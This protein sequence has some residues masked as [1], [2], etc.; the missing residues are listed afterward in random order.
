MK[1]ESL[2]LE[3]FGLNQTIR[4]RDE[5]LQMISDRLDATHTVH[6]D[7]LTGAPLRGKK[8]KPTLQQEQL[9]FESKARG[10]DMGGPN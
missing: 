10:K 3:Q 5:H 6:R 8:R 7:S 9:E 2:L 4:S 1:S